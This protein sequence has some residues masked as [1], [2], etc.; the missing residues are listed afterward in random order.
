MLG[1]ARCLVAAAKPAQAMELLQRV[2]DRFAGT[3]EADTALSWNT[4]LYRLYVRAPGQPA[5]RFADRTLAGRSGRLP[6]IDTLAVDALGT[7]FAAG[8]GAT[9]SFEP[10]GR[11]QGPFAAADPVGVG[12]DPA[13]RPIHALKRGLVRDGKTIALSVRKAD[14][15]V[16][17][18]ED[19]TAIAV[20][21]SGELLVADKGTKSIG[22]FSPDGMLV[23]LF[24]PLGA[25]RLAIDDADRVTV[26]QQ[27]G[28]IALLDADGRTRT[29]L[30]PRGQGYEIDKAVDVALDPLG[31]LYVLDR[32]QG[33]VHVFATRPTPRFVATFSLPRKAPGAF[34][35]AR[36][37]CVDRAGRLYIFDEDAE[38]IQ[39]YQ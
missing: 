16:Q 36:A 6:G 12:F 30:A 14:G 3:P 4:I 7:V 2:R 31:H 10:A 39:V 25:L 19:L 34:R 13:G 20:R 11:M 17:A 37:L 1:E 35:E 5:Y 22:R 24:S 26:L 21:S 28:R 27:D 8:G 33:A 23:D 29:T 15:R 38:R 18:L 9:V 32:G